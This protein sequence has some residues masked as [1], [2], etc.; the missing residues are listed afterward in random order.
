[1][2]LKKY[3]V[4]IFLTA[5]ALAIII[6]PQFSHKPDQQRVDASSIAVTRFFD[7]V[8]QGKYG[9][10]W[11]SCS[12]YLKSEVPKDEFVSRLSAVRK[13]AGKLLDR[14]Q[15]DYLYTKDPGANIPAGEYM[16]YHFDAK[17]ENKDHLTET[18][19]VMLEGGKNWKI[20]GYFI[21]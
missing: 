17:F 7:L 10:S 20:A 21:E 3:R 4:H 5:L 15:K 12:T 1:V 19:T 14:K 2:F 8:D 13:V 9:Q 16:I 11:E 6:Y 18:V